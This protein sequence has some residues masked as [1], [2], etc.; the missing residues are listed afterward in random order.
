MYV[1]KHRVISDEKIHGCTYVHVCY[2][3]SRWT[4]PGPRRARLYYSVEEAKPRRAAAPGTGMPAPATPRA[5]AE[6]L[7]NECVRSCYGL[8]Q[9]KR[10]PHHSPL[11][12]HTFPL[13]PPVVTLTL[14]T[15][16]IPRSWPACRTP[17]ALVS[18]SLSH[19]APPSACELAK[20]VELLC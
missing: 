12:S 9:R 14:P 15:L 11:T 17:S 3:R 10:R 6:T 2:T 4:G 1:H 7:V 19:A 16:W 8:A 18:I 20:L 5:G 13:Q